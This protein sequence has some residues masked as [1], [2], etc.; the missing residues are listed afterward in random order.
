MKLFDAIPTIIILGIVAF[1]A[2]IGYQ[3]YEDYAGQSTDPNVPGVGGSLGVDK[4]AS[5]GA[6][7]DDSLFSIGSSSQDLSTAQSTFFTHP[8]DT[9]GSIFGI[10]SGN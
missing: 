3:V 6:F 8:I 2:W 5:F 7:V 9:L 10:N 4:P 1:L